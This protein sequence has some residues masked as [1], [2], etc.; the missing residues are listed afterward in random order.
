MPGPGFEPGRA[1]AQGILSPL[2]LPVPPS[3]HTERGPH[4]VA[5]HRALVKP[6][7]ERSR[8]RERKLG[9]EKMEA[10]S[11]FEPLNRGF[12]DPS[13]NHLGTPPL[14][15]CPWPTRSMSAVWWILKRARPGSQGPAGPPKRPVWHDFLRHLCP[16]AVA[17]R[18]AVP[19]PQAHIFDSSRRLFCTRSQPFPVTAPGRKLQ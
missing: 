12:A 17:I 3:R 1:F 7:A 14:E 13:L 8:T 10:A 16:P 9:Q 19:R 2:C 6:S 18:F 11:G 15:A 5:A 4:T